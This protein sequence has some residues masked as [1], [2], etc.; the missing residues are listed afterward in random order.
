MV[1]FEDYLN[2]LQELGPFVD[3]DSYA[4]S[5]GTF[6]EKTEYCNVRHVDNIDWLYEA[7]KVVRPDICNHDYDCCGC[8]FLRSIHYVKKCETEYIIQFNWGRNL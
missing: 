7:E 2:K 4:E 8:V 3:W 1:A 6:D 5:V